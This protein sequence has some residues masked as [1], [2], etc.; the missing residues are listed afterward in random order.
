MS[1]QDAE[2]Y[3]AV[4]QRLKSSTKPANIAATSV[5][6]WALGVTFCA[7]VSGLRAGHLP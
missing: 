2:I 5:R 6:G 7:I 4:A 3:G 1:P